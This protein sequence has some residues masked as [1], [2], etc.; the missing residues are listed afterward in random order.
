MH[1]EISNELA[2]WLAQQTE[3]VKTVLGAGTHLMNFVNTNGPA[4]ASKKLL[5]LLEQLRKTG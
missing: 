4:H 5:E 3:F 1:Y 2:R